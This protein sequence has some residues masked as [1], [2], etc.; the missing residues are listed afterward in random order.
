AAARGFVAGRE[1]PLRF[2]ECGRAFDALARS[3]PAARAIRVLRRRREPHPPDSMSVL[4][5]ASCS[6][7]MFFNALLQAQANA[8]Q[9][10]P[11]GFH[12]P[13]YARGDFPEAEAG[14]IT[15]LDDLRGG[16]SQAFRAI[17]QRFL[18]MILSCSSERCFK[19]RPHSRSIQLQAAVLAR[20]PAQFPA[21]L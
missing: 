9:V 14:V 15:Q 2:A 1:D 8:R 10:L 12:R 5:A 13:A 4:R 11:R 21:Y 7:Q 3:P 6:G 16:R 20:L 17:L 18:K 19:R